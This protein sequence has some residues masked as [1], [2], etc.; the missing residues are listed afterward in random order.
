MFKSLRWRLLT[1]HA[2][3]LVLTVVGFGAALYYQIRQA[4]LGE[5]DG[6]LQAAARALEGALRSLP[7]PLL[8]TMCAP[9]PDEPPAPRPGDRGR[10]LKQCATSSPFPARASPRLRT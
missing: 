4:R 8:D 1:W 10:G 9:P 5:I 6:E 2:G 3:I 7:P